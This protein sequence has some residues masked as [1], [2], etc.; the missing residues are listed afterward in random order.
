MTNFEVYI[1]EIIEKHYCASKNGKL[2][3][4]NDLTCDECDFRNTYEECYITLLRWLTQEYQ[5]P[6]MTLTK[7][8]RGLC[9]ALGH[10]WIVRDGNNT[11]WYHNLKPEKRIDL[12]QWICLHGV[13][14]WFNIKVFPDFPF[15]KWENKEP[16]S[17]EEMLTW[18]VENE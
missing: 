18:E 17:I 1:N 8:Q 7:R 15:I 12:N 6:D 11:L 3:S 14:K 9:E 4:C 16:Y 13:S 10:G 2:M 5:K